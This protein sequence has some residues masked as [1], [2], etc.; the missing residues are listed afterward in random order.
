MN[1]MVAVPCLD[2]M[3]S[4]FVI[5]L[6]GLQHNGHNVTNVYAKSS[7]TYDARN[8]LADAAMGYDAVLWL[9]TDMVFNPDTISKF[10][11]DLDAGMDMVCGIYI[12][13]KPPYA[14][15]IYDKYG[16]RK[17]D[18]GTADPVLTSFKKYPRDSV[19]EVAACG[20]GGV[21][22][23]TELLKEVKEKYGLPFSPLL[24]FGEDISFC[25]R[26]NELKRKIWCDSRIK[27]GHVGYT[28]FNEGY[29]EQINRH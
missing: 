29:Y 8:G 2:F 20:F 19:F 28:I 27:F 24:G 22:M 18:D 1:I 21:M 3:M 4:D 10:V 6:T 15:C 14:P 26:V 11:D 16:I 5:A 12:T 7:L 25:I 13:R 23:K 9:D 17:N